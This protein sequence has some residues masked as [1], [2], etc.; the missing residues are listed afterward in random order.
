M[1]SLWHEISLL[2][3]MVTLPATITAGLAKALNIHEQYVREWV[4]VMYIERTSTADDSRIFPA[5]SKIGV[6]GGSP[7]SSVVCFILPPENAAFI[8]WSRSYK[9]VF[10]IPQYISILW[11]LEV[12]TNDYFGSGKGIR[13]RSTVNWKEFWQQ[14]LVILSCHFRSAGY[15][16]SVRISSC[17]FLKQTSKYWT[18]SVAPASISW[19]WQKSTHDSVLLDLM[20]MPATSPCVLI[21]V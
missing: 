6:D 15:S 18:L 5:G 8:T 17:W 19:Q 1:I 21:P 14:T 9:K 10:I 20:R 3:I 7:F 11:P 12:R 13:L 2:G 4:S 16:C